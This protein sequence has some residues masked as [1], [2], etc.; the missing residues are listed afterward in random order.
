MG[1]SEVLNPSLWSHSIIL[2]WNDFTIV[3]CGRQVTSPF[4]LV[5]LSVR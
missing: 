1:E 3:N 5:D 2:Q 4:R